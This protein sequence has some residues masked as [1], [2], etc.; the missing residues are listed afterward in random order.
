M[1]QVGR[2]NQG[3]TFPGKEED[4]PAIDGM[5]EADRLG[6]RQPPGGQDQVAAA[7]GPDPRLAADLRPQA[8]GPGAGGVD[9]GA[10]AGLAFAPRHAVPQ[11]DAG[12]RAILAD[13]AGRRDVVDRHTAVG[14]RL[15]DQAQHQ[16]GVIRLGVAI[17]EAAFQPVGGDVRG[18]HPEVFRA[19]AAVRPLQGHQVVEGE[20]GLVRP[21]AGAVAFVRRQ[22]KAQRV[23]QA[24]AVLQQ[25]LALAHGFQRQAQ[26]ALG[27]VAQPAVHQLRRAA[28]RPPGEVPRLHQQDAQPQPGRLP[29]DARAGD[30]AADDDDV[31]R[32][33]DLLPD[34]IAPVFAPHHDHCFP[35]ANRRRFPRRHSTSLPGLSRPSGSKC[36]IRLR[37]APRPSTP[38]SAAR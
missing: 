15:A 28:A 14:H 27:Q 7:Q 34:A 35:L 12:H 30:P 11:A 21:A 2:A 8:V 31:P 24:G 9:H 1:I 20:T 23:D 33:A 5:Q 19:V 13:Q 18:Q 17:A 25:V 32:R 6:Q 29:Q 22:Q 4:R 10:G 38:F 16:P 37:I 36:A 3:H 26:L